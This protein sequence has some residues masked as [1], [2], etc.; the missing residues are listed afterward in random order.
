MDP[1]I[2]RLTSLRQPPSTSANRAARAGSCAA[3]E[4]DATLNA[5]ADLGCDIAQGYHLGRPMPREEIDAWL[6]AHAEAAAAPLG[7]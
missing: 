4:W 5:L 3:D 2:I 6:A 7:S 1:L